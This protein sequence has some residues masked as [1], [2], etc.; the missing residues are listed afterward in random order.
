LELNASDIEEWAAGT[1]KY[2]H[3]AENIDFQFM[4]AA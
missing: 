2:R 3:R 4:P 1:P